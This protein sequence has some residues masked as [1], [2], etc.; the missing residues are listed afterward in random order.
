MKMPAKQVLIIY[1]RKFDYST[2]GTEHALISANVTNRF[3][4]FLQY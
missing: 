2:L 1:N 4:Q 3:C